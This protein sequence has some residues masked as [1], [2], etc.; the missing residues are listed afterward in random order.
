MLPPAQKSRPGSAAR[1]S[2]CKLGAF[3]QPRY[4]DLSF[5]YWPPACPRSSDPLSWEM[6]T[7]IEPVEQESKSDSASFL[8]RVAEKIGQHAHAKTVYG[9]AVQQ[10]GVTIIPVAKV[11]WG[12]GGGSGK[13]KGK[14]GK[15][16]GGGLKAAPLGYIEI[17]DGQTE[18]KPIRDPA[19]LV[20]LVAVGGLAGWVL[21]RSLRK[22]LRG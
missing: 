19:A 14:S 4:H 2:F 8:E 5:T 9:D 13:K 15:G 22:L 11:R 7:M 21:L 17:K 16:G 3:E 20:P 18:F 10:D 1:V 6:N 12:F